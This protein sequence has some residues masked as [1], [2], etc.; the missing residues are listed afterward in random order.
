MT[1]AVTQLR[2]AGIGW[3]DATSFGCARCGE[4]TVY[5]GA[6]LPPWQ[7]PDLMGEIS[8]N[9]GRFD[10]VTRRV[11]G[12]CALALHDAGVS[13]EAAR[14]AGDIALMGSGAGGSLAANLAY[15]SDYLQAGRTLGGEISLFIRCLRVRSL[16]RRFI[17]A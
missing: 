12:A 9:A 7:Q 16:R 14:T 4:Q 10:P 5:G 3:L 15:F 17:L 8:R 2:V 6:V 11:L 13:P 1:I